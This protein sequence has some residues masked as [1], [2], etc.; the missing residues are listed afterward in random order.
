MP[1]ELRLWY[2][3]VPCLDGKRRRSTWR[4]TEEDARQRYGDAAEKVEASLEVRQCSFGY[5][6]DFLRGP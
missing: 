2:W 6:S 1:D 4:M 3:I 5:T